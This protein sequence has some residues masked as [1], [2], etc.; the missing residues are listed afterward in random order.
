MTPQRTVIDR[1]ELA[2]NIAKEYISVYGGDIIEINEAPVEANSEIT[3]GIRSTE[4][5]E[6][7]TVKRDHTIVIVGK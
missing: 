6:H 7:G 2:V 1:L 4:K 5:H 3:I